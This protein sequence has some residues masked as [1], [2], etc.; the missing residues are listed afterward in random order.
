[1][2]FSYRI[3]SFLINIFVEFFRN[4]QWINLDD[5]KNNGA[6]KCLHFVIIKFFSPINIK[7]GKK[8]IYDEIYNGKTGKKTIM[9]TNFNF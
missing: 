1:M 9:K 7:D 2:E 3:C 4:T 6:L 5:Q 8:L